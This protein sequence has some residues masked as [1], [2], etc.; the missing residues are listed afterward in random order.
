MTP[1]PQKAVCPPPAEKKQTPMAPR[2]PAQVVVAVAGVE[3]ADEIVAVAATHPQ[4]NPATL[5]T[6][7]SILMPLHP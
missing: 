6:Q 2:M 1:K 5:T 7:K 3:D 4:T